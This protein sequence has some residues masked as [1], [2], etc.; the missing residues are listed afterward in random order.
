MKRKTAH[1]L[2]EKLPMHCSDRAVHQLEKGGQ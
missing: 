1:I 2:H